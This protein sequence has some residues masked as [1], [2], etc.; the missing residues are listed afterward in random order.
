MRDPRE[1]D[2]SSV[3]S[4]GDSTDFQLDE[5]ST[6][7][8]LCRFTPTTTPQKKRTQAAVRLLLRTERHVL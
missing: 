1:T 7:G 6:S 3:S 4:E 2:A 8:S 5:L